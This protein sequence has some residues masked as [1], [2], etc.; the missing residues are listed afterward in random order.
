[1]NF[2]GGRFNQFNPLMNQISLGDALIT[3]CTKLW[4]FGIKFIFYNILGT[5]NIVFLYLQQENPNNGINF[6]HL[7]FNY[8]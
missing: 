4:N 2:K 8:I 3:R 5:A 1:M 7:Y 6:N